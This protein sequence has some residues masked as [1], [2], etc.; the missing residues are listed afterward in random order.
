LKSL[1]KLSFAL[2]ET[3][4]FFTKRERERRTCSLLDSFNDGKVTILAPTMDSTEIALRNYEKIKGKANKM[5]YAY[6][7]L[8]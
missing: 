4:T 1:I 2:G 6:L 3:L 5:P 8:T 7:M